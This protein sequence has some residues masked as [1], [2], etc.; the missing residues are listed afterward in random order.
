[1]SERVWRIGFCMSNHGIDG[2]VSVNVRADT[3][4]EAIKLAREVCE[5]QLGAPVAALFDR[6]A[7]VSVPGATF[8]KRDERGGLSEW[9][10]P[11]ARRVDRLGR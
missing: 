6:V 11:R 5:R 7:G 3:E 9:P 8:W 4:R 1:M 10:M 2:S